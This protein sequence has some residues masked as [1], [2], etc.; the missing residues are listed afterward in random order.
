MGHFAVHSYHV[1][2][3]NDEGEKTVV[4]HHTGSLDQALFCLKVE[5]LWCDLRTDTCKHR[6]GHRRD[7]SRGHR[8]GRNTEP[9]ESTCGRQRP[10][11]VG[12]QC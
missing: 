8:R 12:T 6:R 11:V 1:A 5:R 7:R 2:A 9:L 4:S 10:T 3:T